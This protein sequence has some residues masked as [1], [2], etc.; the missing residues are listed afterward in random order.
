MSAQQAVISL[1]KRI[2]LWGQHPLVQRTFKS[3]LHI[4]FAECLGG[5]FLAF[6]IWISTSQYLLQFGVEASVV[7]PLV[8]VAGLVLAA[9]QSLGPAR[10]GFLMW[11]GVPIWLMLQPLV[12]DWVQSAMSGLAWEQ[13]VNPASLIPL[14]A[15]ACLV[16]TGP[17]WFCVGRIVWGFDRTS[18]QQFGFLIAFATSLALFPVAMQLLPGT[19][20][21]SLLV[22]AG[23]AG[24]A[25]SSW[26]SN[27]SPS[28]STP[29]AVDS[30]PALSPFVFTLTGLVLPTLMHIA[31]QLVVA[32]PFTLGCLWSGLLLGTVFSL[33]FSPQERLAATRLLTLA[34]VCIGT[35]AMYPLLT[36]VHFRLTANVA[37]LW[38]LFPARG[39][40]LA[41]MWLPAGWLLGD[42]L[43]TRGSAP[44][45]T[46]LG[47]VW[48]TVG[49]MAGFMIAWSPAMT[50]TACGLVTL[51]AGLI[52]FPWM[53]PRVATRSH[54]VPMTSMAFLF[55]IGLIGLWKFTRLDTATSERLLFNGNSFYALRD[56]VDPTWI[57]HLDDRRL[58][59]EH[60][61]V[62]GRWS[63]WRFRA[64]QC[65]IRHN[66]ILTA[67]CA[68][69]LAV[70]PLSPTEVMPVAIPMSLAVRTDDIL[71][72]GLNGPNMVETTLEYP[73][74]SVTVVESDPVAIS[75]ARQMDSQFGMI[76]FQDERVAVSQVSPLIAMQ[77]NADRKYDVIVTSSSQIARF[78][79]QP[80]FT[81]EFYR[82]VLRH[83]NEDGIFC[84]RLA[85]FDLGPKI[86][87][88]MLSTMT[89]AFPQVVAVETAPGELLLI[90]N[91]T[92]RELVTTQLI[93][94]LQ[95]PH[96]RRV[97]S[98]VGWDWSAAARMLFTR[99]P[100]LRSLAATGRVESVSNSRLTWKLPFEVSRWDDKAV[101]TRLA[102]AEHSEALGKGLGDAPEAMD[103]EH[104]LQDVQ[105]KYV[106]MAKNPDQYWG[107]RKTLKERL[108]DR[109]RTEIVQVKHEGLTRAL[110]SEDARRKDYL[111][112]LGELAK[113]DAP[114]SEQIEELTRFCSPYDPLICDF[115]HYEAAH[116]YAKSGAAS[117][118]LAYEHWLHCV[119]SS[120]P[121]DRSV[122]TV[123][124]AIQMLC[125]FPESVATPA[126]R[127]DHLNTLLEELERRWVVRL[128][129]QDRSKYEPI[130]I[131]RSIESAQAATKVLAEIA[132][133]VRVS[134]ADWM[135][136]KAVIDDTVLRPLRA[137]RSLQTHL[138]SVP[139]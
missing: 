108:Q 11:L 44:D 53:Q 8:L 130:D 47:L 1:F 97:F 15:L 77:S 107:Y 125:Q 22:A 105:Q 81:V 23:L 7:L 76:A 139:N 103:I 5:S 110:H 54:L 63:V 84:Q 42:V 52:T 122:R 119:L 69:P 56:E 94:R 25:W 6:A 55:V 118:R 136:R 70:G 100:E 62:D 109:P 99:N 80:T 41:L 26:R 14:L 83:L 24:L 61:S 124:A 33:Y 19:W 34:F 133:Q 49:A 126:D 31:H 48:L 132:P 116:L 50:L 60:D 18:M 37:S 12:T 46:G 13:L 21:W 28:E 86:V 121:D 16:M 36:A 102:F 57:S 113:T 59:S 39:S 27:N 58:L 123:C 73:V 67:L 87:K 2:A 72:L 30:S 40:L 65:E 74:R 4:P 117:P 92:P 137:Q 17:L 88:D 32:S 129:A 95:Q 101:Q 75:M 114:T 111:E 29:A 106:L 82:N 127:W 10:R 104:R 35:L 68:P 138:M 131:D 51:T 3:I 78:E 134:E 96:S 20:A 89:A 64:N 66:G 115:A 120:P 85:Y 128:T 112:T 45:Q 91:R 98:R 71:L 93:D 38:F 135:L 43:R 79:L 90:A 9:A